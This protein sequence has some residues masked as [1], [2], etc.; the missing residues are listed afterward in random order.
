MLGTLI[1]WIQKRAEL[2]HGRLPAGRFVGLVHD[3]RH[4]VRITAEVPTVTVRGAI[5]LSAF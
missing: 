4:M 2:D 3:H 5:K 1:V